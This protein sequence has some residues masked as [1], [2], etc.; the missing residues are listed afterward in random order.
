MRDPA[1]WGAGVSI[2]TMDA[3]RRRGLQ[4][5]WIGLGEGWEGVAS[6]H[7]EAIAAGGRC[8]YLG[9]PL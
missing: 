8:G 7:P 4:R 9:G 3:L 1:R 6:G 2:E 5:L